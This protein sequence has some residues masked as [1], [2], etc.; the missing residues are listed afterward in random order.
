M[1]VQLQLPVDAVNTFVVPWKAS[2]IAQVQEAKAKAP[3]AIVVGHARQPLGDCIVLN[4]AA[5]HVAIAGLADLK[6]LPFKDQRCGRWSLSEKAALVRRSYKLGMSLSLVARQ[7]GARLGCCSSG[8]SSSVMHI[9]PT[10][11]VRTNKKAPNFSGTKT[12]K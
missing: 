4:V 3:V 6:R 1:Q 8:A 12:W 2:H 5:S 10:S 7:K 9:S 11:A